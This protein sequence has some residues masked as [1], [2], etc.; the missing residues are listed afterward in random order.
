MGLKEVQANGE[1]FMFFF[2]NS[3]SCS[4]VLEG[5]PWYIGNQLLILKKWKRMMRL[6]KEQVS[7]IPVWVKLFNVP[8]EY[9]DDEGL[10]RIASKIG[11][12][13][14]MDH[15]SSS[16]NRISFA[17]CEHCK[18]FGHNSKNC[19]A[20]HVEKLVQMQKET[21]HQPDDEWTLVKAKGKH[22]IAESNETICSQPVE[23]TSP[24]DTLGD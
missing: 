5:G 18:V 11:V 14:F 24:P 9:W 23:H 19:V 17:R 10:S 2:E 15:L 6:T 3:D 1:G 22:K 4:K 12:P 21:D 20:A 8:M 16:G 13:L 7:Q